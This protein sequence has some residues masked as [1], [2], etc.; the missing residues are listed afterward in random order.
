M[1]NPFLN[2][3]VT[4]TSTVMD[5][6]VCLFFL[7]LFHNLKVSETG[8]YDYI[9]WFSDYAVYNKGRLLIDRRW[10]Y[11][12][13]LSVLDNGIKLIHYSLCLTTH[14]CSKCLIIHHS[15]AVSKLKWT[16]SGS[17]HCKS[18]VHSYKTFLN[19]TWS[20]SNPHSEFEQS[21]CRTIQVKIKWFRLKSEFYVH[22]LFYL[23]I[24][25]AWNKRNNAQS[26]VVIIVKLLHP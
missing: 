6:A 4:V 16:L 13:L 10:L 20:P 5:S 14:L 2:S 18:W 17:D 24:L 1:C 15:S 25:L 9:I 19:V 26:S 11:T 12:T 7:F 22:L 8:T 23:L 3:M 21:I